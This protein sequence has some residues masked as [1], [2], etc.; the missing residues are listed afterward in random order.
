[1]ND[2]D[3]LQYYIEKY[4]IHTFFSDYESWRQRLRFVT[5][6]K[7]TYLDFSLLQKNQ[8]IFFVKGRFKVCG[9]LSNGRQILYR[10][11]LMMHII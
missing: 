9:D 11:C 8:I 7:K 2:A 6:P 4:K 5:Y 10:L 3:V 1:M